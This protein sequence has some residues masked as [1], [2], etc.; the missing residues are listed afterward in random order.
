MKRKDP[1]EEARRYVDNARE[2][3]IANAII[4]RCAMLMPKTTPA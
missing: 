4:N 3:R 1:I 2:T